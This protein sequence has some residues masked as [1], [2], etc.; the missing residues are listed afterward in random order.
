MW[1][2]SYFPFDILETHNNCI[3]C[4]IIAAKCLRLYIQLKQNI[5]VPK[6]KQ[7]IFEHFQGKKKRMFCICGFWRV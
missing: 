3:N 5:K 7:V 1:L 4:I 2:Q 6:S